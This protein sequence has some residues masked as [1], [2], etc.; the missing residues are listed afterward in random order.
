VP[1]THN[2]IIRKALATPNKAFVQIQGANHYYR[3]QPEKMQECL[4]AVLDWS[5]RQKLL[6]H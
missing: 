3:G 6:A 4:S 2:P 1:A 5:R